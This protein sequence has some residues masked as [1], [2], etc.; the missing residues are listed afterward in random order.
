[1]I[2]NYFI[3]AFRNLRKHRFFGFINV[4][5]LSIGIASALLISL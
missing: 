2:R 1:M 3:I 4:T 5:G